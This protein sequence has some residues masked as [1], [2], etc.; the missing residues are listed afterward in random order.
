ME[1]HDALPLMHEYLDGDLEGPEALELKKH[2]IACPSCSALFKEMERTEAMVRLMPRSP[3][4]PSLTTASIMARIPQPKRRSRWFTWVKNHPAVSVASVFLL[5]MISSFV[6]LG[7]SDQ[8]MVVKGS[9]L[10]Q[11][12][13]R[14]DT[15]IVPAGTTVE[16][17]LM[18]KRGK[19]QVEGSVEGNLTV[20]DGSYNLAST[21]YIAG[22]VTK[23]DETLEWIWFQINEFFTA[24]AK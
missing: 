13:I 4:P 18:V 15:V 6:A 8:D 3:V 5:V 1:C 14:G 22:H 9:H 19:I 7:R 11:V 16:G 17:D 23:V 20:V 12:V 10:D 24:L 2:L 21:A